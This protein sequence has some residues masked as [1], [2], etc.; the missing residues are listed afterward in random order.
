MNSR[1]SPTPRKKHKTRMKEL[2]RLSVEA[3]RR[4]RE[5]NMQNM[6]EDTAM[7]IEANK[8]NIHD[9]MP[10]EEYDIEG[11]STEQLFADDDSYVPYPEEIK[12]EEQHL[13]GYRIINMI[14]LQSFISNL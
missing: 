14:N 5:E 9:Y 10:T 6:I 11:Q 7:T 1:E 3:R 12:E 4:V 8:T 13:E 2:A